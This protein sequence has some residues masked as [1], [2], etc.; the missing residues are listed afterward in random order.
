MLF[1]KVDGK[2]LKTMKK[3][4]NWIHAPNPF[5][6]QIRKPAVIFLLNS[7]FFTNQVTIYY[8]IRK[9]SKSQVELVKIHFGVEFVQPHPI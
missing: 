6:E 5:V 2:N 3:E 4:M 1:A 9:F 7:L 8:L